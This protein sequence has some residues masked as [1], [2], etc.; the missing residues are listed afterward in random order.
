[1]S[2]VYLCGS[3][4][5]VIEKT[6]HCWATVNSTVQENHCW[7]ELKPAEDSKTVQLSMNGHQCSK[8]N[9]GNSR[10]AGHTAA[11]SYS[12]T[13]SILAHKKQ[14]SPFV[15]DWYGCV[16]ISINR[17]AVKLFGLHWI[18]FT[19]RVDH[20]ETF[21]RHGP[22]YTDIFWRLWWYPKIFTWC[23]PTPLHWHDKKG[24]TW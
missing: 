19:V 8:N 6:N 17:R 13:A 1:M 14:N 24:L 3:A 7:R 20:C 11:D 12:P 15:G 4:K 5:H 23:N 22:T 10:L 18:H 2:S 9:T 16:H 21:L